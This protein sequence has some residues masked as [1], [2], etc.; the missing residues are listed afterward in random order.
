M[1]EDV[2]GTHVLILEVVDFDSPPGDISWLLK[3]SKE[4][5]CFQVSMTC[6]QLC[7]IL[8][9]DAM[10]LY[11][12]PEEGEE[13]SDLLSLQQV[14]TKH[15]WTRDNGSLLFAEIH[16]KQHGAPVEAVI[17]NTKEAKA[18][19]GAMN[20][21]LPAFIKHYLLGKGL[22]QD[23]VTWLVVAA[24]CPVL[25]GESNRVKCDPEKLEVIMSDDAKDNARLTAFENQEWYF[26]LNKLCV[27]PKKKKKHYTAPEALFNLDADR[28]VITLH[29]KNNVKHA[30]ARDGYGDIDSEEEDTDSASNECGN[31]KSPDGKAADKEGG[32]GQKSI[33]W[34]PSGSSV[35]RLASHEV[36]GGG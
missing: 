18:M 26:D 32:D 2:W 30:A 28:S 11:K 5:I 13:A 24:C 36:A 33:S 16:Q 19:V 1:F 25:V 3:E 35:E 14:L 7:R 17:P 9:L 4:H 21:Q 22:D 23:F 34:S 31:G 27:S 20:R 12:Q 6:T 10:V 15:F 8:D 29:A